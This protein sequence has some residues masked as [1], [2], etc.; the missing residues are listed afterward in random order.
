M[1]SR[2]QSGFEDGLTLNE[3]ALLAEVSERSVTKAL[4][5]GVLVALKAAAGASGVTAGRKTLDVHAV[6]YFGLMNGLRE[7]GWSIPI[8]SKKRI[9][10]YVVDLSSRKATDDLELNGPVVL[11]KSKSFP[12]VRRYMASAV[13]YLSARRRWIVTDDSVKGGTPVIRGSRMTVYSV[14]GRIDGGDTLDMIVEDNPDI[15]R[16]ALEAALL[17]ARANP[18]RGRPS[19]RPWKQ[20]A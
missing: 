11:K 7:G 4:E 17:F 19:G 12:V 9:A 2:T 20:A 5:E 16:G 3:V 13:R 10:R 18:M 8:E 14:L 15:P 1:P 6:G